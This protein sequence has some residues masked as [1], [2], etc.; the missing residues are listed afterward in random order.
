MTYDYAFDKRDMGR[1]DKLNKLT[2]ANTFWQDMR[3]LLRDTHSDH[4]LN[5]WQVLAEIRYEE[6]TK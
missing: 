1:I 2:D 3:K 6:L 5:R 4:A